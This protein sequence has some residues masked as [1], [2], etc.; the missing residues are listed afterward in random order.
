MNRLTHLDLFSGIGGFSLAAEAAGWRTVAFCEIDPEAR[1]VT[2][3][4]WPGVPN[5]KDVKSITRKQVDSI[6]SR[7]YYEDMLNEKYSE[8]AELYNKGLSIGNLAEY[9]KISRQAMW[10]IL[11]RRGV[12]FRSQTRSGEE[13]VFHRGG[14]LANGRVHDLVAIAVKSGTLIPRGCEVCGKEAVAHHDDYNK[15]LDVRWLCKPHHYDWHSKFKAKPLTIDLP[16]KT[17][18]ESASIAGLA[19][20]AKRT[21]EQKRRM[22]ELSHQARYGKS[23]QKGGTT[24]RTLPDRRIDLIT[25]GVP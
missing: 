14:S 11:K 19:S 21:L 1:M 24:T 4:W 6:V 2:D 16:K 12:T 7:A 3:Y 17:R 23:N 18:A 13:N 8:S 20:A 15:P 10:K 25:G 9:Y 5:L 22:V